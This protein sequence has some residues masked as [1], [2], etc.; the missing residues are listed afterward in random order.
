MANW[1]TGIAGSRGNML[2]QDFKREPVAKI[3]EYKVCVESLEDPRARRKKNCGIGHGWISLNRLG[4]L[5]NLNR[6]H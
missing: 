4:L 6:G 2:T 3:P 1:A 5:P